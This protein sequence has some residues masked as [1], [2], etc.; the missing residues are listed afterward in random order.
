MA[1]MSTVEDIR[2][3]MRALNQQ[4]PPKHYLKAKR[5]IG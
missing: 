4:K 2:N 1:K 3:T 5:S